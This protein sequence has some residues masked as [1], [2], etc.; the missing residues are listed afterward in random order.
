MA[1]NIYHESSK[2]AANTKALTTLQGDT[3][4]VMYQEGSTHHFVFGYWSVGR[5]AAATVGQD[6][7]IFDELL[8]KAEW[9]AADPKVVKFY[10]KTG[11]STFDSTPEFT[12]AFSPQNVGIGAVVSTVT[13]VITGTAAQ[14]G[15]SF[16][17]VDSSGSATT[18]L[19]SAESLRSVMKPASM[20]NSV[21]P[22]VS[23]TE[24]ARGISFG[25]TDEAGVVATTVITRQNIV[26]MLEGEYA[27][28]GAIT[29]SAATLQGSIDDLNTRTQALEAIDDSAL[30]ARVNALEALDNT[31]LIARIE[32]LEAVDN[33]VLTDR[34]RSLEKG[35]YPLTFNQ[36]TQAHDTQDT[37]K[38]RFQ[39]GTLNTSGYNKINISDDIQLVIAQHRNLFYLV[40]NGSHKIS[41]NTV[42]R[43]IGNNQ[44]GGPKEYDRG[45]T[46][47]P[48][49]GTE[50]LKLGNTGGVFNTNPINHAN[51]FE[52]VLDIDLDKGGN[53]TP[54]TGAR[55]L[56][57]ILNASLENTVIDNSVSNPSRGY[58][59][60][61]T[62]HSIYGQDW[63]GGTGV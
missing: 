53:K 21:T 43:P 37:Y 35:E 30:S 6:A 62:L 15:L 20:V 41:V 24:A 4:L 50:N 51:S 19:V 16:T 49:Q 26:G 48:G 38:N 54:Y 39:M 5:G 47:N 52:M 2:A 57:V 17:G 9:D 28:S 12:L 56:H 63:S 10:R 45:I 22:I 59:M 33:T 60:T 27:T 7:A 58:N 61:Y 44:S 3:S 1:F 42:V 11:D 36:V 18:Q 25:T 46:A 34:V 23:G 40:N 55:T 14:R 8:G 32:A 13:P 29:S 31:A